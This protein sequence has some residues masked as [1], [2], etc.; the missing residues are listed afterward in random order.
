MLKMGRPSKIYKFVRADTP[1]QPISAAAKLPQHLSEA[2]AF[3]DLAKLTPV[4]GII[5][6]DVNSPFWSDGASKERWMAVPENEKITFRPTTAFRSRSARSSS[7]TS[8][9]PSMKRTARGGGSKRVSGP[10]RDG[11]RLWNYL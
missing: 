3:T 8:T 7:K 5:P 11:G 10:E 2:H 9:W 6:Y 4:A 1:R